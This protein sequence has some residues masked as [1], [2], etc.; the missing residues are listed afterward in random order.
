PKGKLTLAIFSYPT[1][2]IARER[3]EEFAKIPGAVVKRAGPMV[4]VTI[5]PPDA[6]A[7]ERVLALVRYEANVTLN[8]T[9]PVNAKQISGMLLSIFALAGLVLLLCLIAGIG[10]GAFRVL[11]RKMGWNPE[12]RDAMIVLHLGNK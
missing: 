10:F 1:P 5:Q 4:A 7:A 6:D 3:Y 2:G 8:E 9:P 11:L 12:E